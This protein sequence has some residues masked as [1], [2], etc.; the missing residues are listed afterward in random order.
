MGEAADSFFR[1]SLIR[2]VPGERLEVKYRPV[3][4]KVLLPRWIHRRRAFRVRVLIHF[5]P[6]APAFTGQR[7]SHQRI[8]TRIPIAA[9][10]GLDDAPARHQLDLAPLYV[11]AEDRERGAL[12]GFDPG[13]FAGRGGE[14]GSV[15]Q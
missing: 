13:R 14:L 1:A 15:G 2:Q 10:P 7:E 12:A 8:E 6:G 9:A 4:G 11:A 3:G 5:E